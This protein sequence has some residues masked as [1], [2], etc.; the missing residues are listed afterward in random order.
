MAVQRIELCRYVDGDTQ[1]TIDGAA[2]LLGTT[3][4]YILDACGPNATFEEL[5]ED[6][7]RQGQERSKIAKDAMGTNITTVILAF[8]ARTEW[9]ARIDFHGSAGQMWAVLDVD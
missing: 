5:P 1:P 7:K 4:E 6:L 8:W 2:L 3:V 9:N